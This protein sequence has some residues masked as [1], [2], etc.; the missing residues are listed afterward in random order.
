MSGKYIGMQLILKKQNN[1]VD[2]IPR[3]DY[4]LNLVGQSAVDRCVEVVSY[5]GFLQPVYTG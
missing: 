1:L 3:A 2:C 5:C 4:S